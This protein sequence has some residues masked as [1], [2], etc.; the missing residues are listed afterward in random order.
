MLVPYF[1]HVIYI[2]LRS[3]K[4]DCKNVLSKAK[5]SFTLLLGSESHVWINSRNFWLENNSHVNKD[6]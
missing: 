1:E 3:G 5:N 2:Q 6:R 4:M